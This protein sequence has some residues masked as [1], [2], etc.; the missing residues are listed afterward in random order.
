MN[1]DLD[2]SLNTMVLEMIDEVV[3]GVC[4]E[5]HRAA[6][7]DATT[8]SSDN[9]ENEDAIRRPIVQPGYDVFGRPP[10]K[11]AVECKCPSCDRLLVVSRFAPHLEKC[12]GM[13]RNSTRSAS[14]RIAYAA[15]AAAASSSSSSTSVTKEASDDDEEDDWLARR[16]Q[17]RLKR[18][19]GLYLTNTP[20]R[21]SKK[22]DDLI[23]N[24]SGDGIDSTLNKRLSP[25]AMEFLK[26]PLEKRKDYLL[27]TCGV[28]SEHSGKMCTRSHRCPQHS[29]SQRQSVWELLIGEPSTGV[30]SSPKEIS[31]D[32][33]DSVDGISD[34]SP[35]VASSPASSSSQSVALVSSPLKRTSKSKQS[36]RRKT[37][38]R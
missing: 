24:E 12:M 9:E 33:V 25:W 28:I 4:F 27:M 17:R 16:D 19:H 38:K 2:I 7:R 36:N 34:G 31:V 37:R 8:W 35:N 14:R 29:V 26:Q 10:P 13:G 22:S 6:K 23:S 32:V 11:K 18:D 21:P 3:L 1:G 15:A 5:A 20:P 30:Y